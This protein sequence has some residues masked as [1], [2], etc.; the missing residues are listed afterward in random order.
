[1][2]KNRAVDGRNNICGRRIKAL[3]EAMPARPS[4]KQ[5]ADRL[6]LAGL[7][8]DKN[9]VQRMESG[10]RFVT[11]IELKIIAQVLKVTYQDL[12]DE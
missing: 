11:D 5:F 12:L 3:R 1:M 8:V 6:Q 9:A 7:D 10:Q 4:Q 2:Y